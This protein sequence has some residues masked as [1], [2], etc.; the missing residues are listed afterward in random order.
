MVPHSLPA[1]PPGLC[2]ALT[3]VLSVGGCKGAFSPNLTLSD[4]STQHLPSGKTPTPTLLWSCLW[5][6][7]ALGHRL[8]I[9]LYHSLT[10]K[11]KWSQL[12]G[13]AGRYWSFSQPCELFG[14]ICILFMVDLPAQHPALFHEVLSLLFPFNR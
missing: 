11:A 2:F 3:A 10:Y 6:F 4:G 5:A 7:M 1:R 12:G 9:I 13:R 8:I 14:S